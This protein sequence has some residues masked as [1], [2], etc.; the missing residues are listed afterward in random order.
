MGSLRLIGSDT[1]DSIVSISATLPS[2]VKPP[3]NVG[4]E[5]GTK[6]IDGIKETDGSREG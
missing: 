4:M 2:G 5:E 1:S 6:D 3:Q